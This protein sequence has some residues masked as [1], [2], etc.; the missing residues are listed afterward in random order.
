MAQS[1]LVTKRSVLKILSNLFAKYKMPYKPSGNDESF[2]FCAEAPQAI[3]ALAPEYDLETVIQT[4]KDGQS[5]NIPNYGYCINK[6]LVIDLMRNGLSGMNTTYDKP[7][8]LSD[9]IDIAIAFFKLRSLCDDNCMGLDCTQ[10]N[11]YKAKRTALIGLNFYRKA[12]D[13]L[14][15]I[16]YLK[17]HE[18]NESVKSCYEE[19]EKMMKDAYDYANDRTNLC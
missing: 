10:C 3:E 12:E 7:E 9:E 16:A 19:I 17:D 1:D 2:G 4:I 18:E 15:R 5:L 13:M 6:D 8:N 11:R 14:T